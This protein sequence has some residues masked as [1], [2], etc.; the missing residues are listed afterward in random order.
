MSTFFAAMFIKIGAGFK[1]KGKYPAL[2][3]LVF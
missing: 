1:A 3:M 2:N